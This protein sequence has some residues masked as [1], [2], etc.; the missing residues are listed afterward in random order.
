MK[1]ETVGLVAFAGLALIGFLFV[2]GVWL[3]AAISPVASVRVDE[4][5]YYRYTASYTV[6]ETGEILDVNVVVP[7]RFK[8]T[9]YKGGGS[10]RDPLIGADWFDQPYA[11][12]AYKFTR[13]GHV[14]LIGAP[15]ACVTRYV[16]PTAGPDHN[17]LLRA[18]WFDDADLRFGW[19]YASADA[20]QSPRAK[21]EFHGANIQRASADDYAA[22]RRAI[23][24]GFVPH[25]SIQHSFGF[26]RGET[27]TAEQQA[28]RPDGFHYVPFYCHGVSRLPLSPR[29]RGVA[30]RYWPKGHPKYWDIASLPD[31]GRK[32]IYNELNRHDAIEGDHSL[33]AYDYYLER[34]AAIVPVSGFDFSF[35]AHTYLPAPYYPITSVPTSAAR[36]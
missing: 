22:W 25:G 9:Q 11:N 24:V 27:G 33:D 28:F 30:A 1:R 14:L 3:P 16:S 35:I 23:N 26:K 32:D 36:A 17:L 29:M 18:Y 34:S 31:S 4:G 10:S 12:I 15:G 21:I 6:K 5:Y 13:D 2:K 7:C 20:Y 8:V 19:M